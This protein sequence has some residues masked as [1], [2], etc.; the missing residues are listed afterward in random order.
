MQFFEPTEVDMASSNLTIG[1]YMM[2]HGNIRI[3]LLFQKNGQTVYTSYRYFKVIHYGDFFH[4]RKVPHSLLVSW[5]LDGDI[6]FDTSE[7]FFAS[8][9]ESYG[10]ITDSRLRKHPHVML[11]KS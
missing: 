7:S 4:K 10:Y 5:P 3:S 1:P 2:P 8:R 11:V 6:W 9:K